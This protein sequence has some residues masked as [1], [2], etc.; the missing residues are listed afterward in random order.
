MLFRTS[1]TFALMTTGAF[2][3]NVGKKLFSELKLVTDNL[4]STFLKLDEKMS[5]GYK[6]I[7]ELGSTPSHAMQSNL[8]IFSISGSRRAIFWSTCSTACPQHISGRWCGS[9]SGPVYH[10]TYPRSAPQKNFHYFISII[11]CVQLLVQVVSTCVICVK[12]IKVGFF[13]YKVQVY[14]KLV[15]ILPRG[16]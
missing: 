16:C 14:Y 15:Y 5:P 4:P 2:S 7:V 11:E 10:W 1:F 3:R 6:T 9:C 12:I 8:M 13:T